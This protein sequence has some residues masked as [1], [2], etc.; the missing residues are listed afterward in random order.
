MKW[1]LPPALLAQLDQ[2]V[3]AL[4]IA[5]DQLIAT[6]D[7]VLAETD[8]GQAIATLTLGLMAA[9]SSSKSAAIAAVAITR[10]AEG[11]CRE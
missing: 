6:A 7:M 2:E 3:A 1:E 5:V 4:N 10:L 9:S 11:Q 8:R